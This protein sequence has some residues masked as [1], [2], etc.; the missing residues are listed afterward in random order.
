MV[1]NIEKVLERGERIDLLV[2]RTEEMQEQ[3]YKF[4]SGATELKK[5]LWWKN[6]K[7]W[8]VIA[9]LVIVRG[10]PS[11]SVRG[12]DIVGVDSHLAHRVRCLRL[13]LLQV[14]VISIN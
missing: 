6:V 11:I 10:D 14:P 8:L 9:C 2:T 5:K 4:K 13:H 1:Q 3:S 7:L 12:A